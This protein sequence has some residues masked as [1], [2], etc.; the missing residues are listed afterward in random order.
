MKKD[1]E[2]CTWTINNFPR[3]LKNRFLAHAKSE[4]Q[5]GLA[6]LQFV[7]ARFLRESFEKVKKE[8]IHNER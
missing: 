8:I 6:L 3:R 7:I 5:T 2:T 1:K 4:N